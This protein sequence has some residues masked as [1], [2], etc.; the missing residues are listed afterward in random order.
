M[1]RAPVPLLEGLTVALSRCSCWKRQDKV[2]EAVVQ[3]HVTVAYVVSFFL[4]YEVAQNLK[5]I[6]KIV[7]TSPIWSLDWDRPVINLKGIKRPKIDAISMG[8][9]N[10]SS[11]Y[12]FVQLC[13]LS[14]S[15]RSAPQVCSESSCIVR[16]A[17]LLRC[18]FCLFFLFYF[19][20]GE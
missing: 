6:Y 15:L 19:L 1:Q 13:Q 11:N 5:T 9:F 3:G 4:W 18:I 17:V 7:S 12:W 8:N 16:N 14:P 2:L 20:G 10:H